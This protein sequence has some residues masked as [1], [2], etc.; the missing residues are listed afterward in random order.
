VR[1]P[2]VNL[3]RVGMG[4]LLEDYQNDI[5]N[6]KAKLNAQR[7]GF[8]GY[9]PPPNQYPPAGPLPPPEPPPYMP[10]TMAPPPPPPPSPSGGN[11]NILM[12]PI[13][14]EPGDEV[15][16]TVPTGYGMRPLHPPVSTGINSGPYAKPPP[17]FPPA[18][19]GCPSG[20]SI[21][22]VTGKCEQNP[23]VQTQSP[24]YTPP[25]PCPMGWSRKNPGDPCTQNPATPTPGGTSPGQ[26]SSGGPINSTP[27][28]NTAP[29]ATGGNNSVA[30]PG[31]CGPGKF[32]DGTQCR[33]SVGSM[34]TMPGGA[35][36]SAASGQ[37]PG[38]ELN[39]GSIANMGGRAF[40][41]QVRLRPPGPSMG[42]GNIRI[43]GL[44]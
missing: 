13:S 12:P 37:A 33:G 38:G 19:Q 10:G 22:E 1:Y 39:P 26:V 29:G 21:S 7:S 17:E 9:T 20:W 41:G 36:G 5:N 30:T 4:G 6:L 35:S 8:A 25:V 14:V 28:W 27:S 44:Y 40:L 23:P 16:P 2:V 43:V 32:W 24:G 42:R 3:R 15:P 11:A 34:P 18:E 31:G